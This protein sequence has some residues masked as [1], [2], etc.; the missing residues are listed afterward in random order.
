MGGEPAS[1]KRHRAA[2][3]AAAPEVRHTFG[4]TALP[5]NVKATLQQALLRSQHNLCGYCDREIRGADRMKIDH[6]A[7]QDENPDRDIDWSNLLAV[8]SDG[9]GAATQH[10]DTR[11]GH[12]PLHLHPKVP[13]GST[14][15]IR[16]SGDVRNRARFQ[17]L[18]ESQNT[19][20]ARVITRDPRSSLR[21]LADGSIESD[22]P[23]VQ[24]DVNDVL[25][26][27]SGDLRAAR[28]EAIARAKT[29]IR[30]DWT[31]AELDRR[32]RKVEQSGFGAAAAYA[33]RQIR[34]AWL[35]RR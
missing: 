29:G 3:R 28:K 18:E 19:L 21:F 32:I 22:D 17:V 15:T 33:L 27:N 10:C 34:E 14:V 24:D 2:R 8:C 12:T 11:K 6:W 5:A 1:L 4:Y 30:N 20:T 31:I 35:R 7:P 13:G 9:M 16:F 25:G 26:L 23:D